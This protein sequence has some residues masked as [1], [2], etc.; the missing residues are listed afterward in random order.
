MSWSSGQRKVLGQSFRNNLTSS[1]NNCCDILPKFGWERISS[2]SELRLRKVH[3]L[4]SI[5]SSGCNLSIMGCRCVEQ[6]S[7]RPIP[8]KSLE[9]QVIKVPA[10]WTYDVFTLHIFLPSNLEY[11]RLLMLLLTINKSGL[12]DSIVVLNTCD[13]GYQIDPRHFDGP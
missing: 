3:H 8:K 11:Y 9:N 6:P 4:M 7:W 13:K 5:T 10:K 1:S 2:P 12:F